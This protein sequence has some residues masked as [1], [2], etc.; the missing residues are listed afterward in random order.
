LDRFYYIFSICVKFCWPFLS[1]QPFIH[2]TTL[3][4]F[5]SREISIISTAYRN[6]NVKICCPRRRII[7][8]LK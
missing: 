1:F 8:S 4:N 3:Q 6:N 5:K 7:L 2:P